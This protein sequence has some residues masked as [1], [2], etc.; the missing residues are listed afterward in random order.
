MRCLLDQRAITFVKAFFNNED[1]DDIE[2]D[3][4]PEKWSSGLHL[5]PPPH[6]KTFKIKSWK[7]KVDYYPSVIDVSALREGSIVELVNLSPIQRMVITLDEVIVVDSHGVGPVFGET[8]SCWVKEICA[9]Q[10]HKFLANARPFEPFT[11]VGQGLTDL[12]I[13]PYE[14][15]KQG[16][17]IQ[18]AMKKGMK[19]LAETVVFQTLTTSSSLTKF[20]ADIMADSIGRKGIYNDVANPLPTRPL[21]VPKGIG[22]ARLHA[23]KSLARGINAANYK[24]VVVPYR[25]FMRNGVTGAVTSVI[26]AIPVLLVAPLTGATEAASYTLLGARNSLRPDIRKEEEASMNLR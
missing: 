11:D 8:V 7:V 5:L 19:S 12:V 6:F 9:T 10:L 26:K 2:K 23:A 4:D 3:T 25:E 21:S 18:R 24:V 22:D 16:D 14:A 20:A 17:S 15:F 13:L 1:N